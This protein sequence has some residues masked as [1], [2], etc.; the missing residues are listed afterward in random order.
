MRMYGKNFRYLFVCPKLTKSKPLA[1][2]LRYTSNLTNICRYEALKE[3]KVREVEKVLQF[4]TFNYDK[5][6]LSKRL[7]DDFDIFKRY[8]RTNTG[9]VKMDTWTEGERKEAR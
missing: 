6:D 2:L 3:N 7:E 9:C 5:E 8:A 1:I 4:L